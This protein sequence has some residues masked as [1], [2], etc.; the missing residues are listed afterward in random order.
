MGSATLFFRN[1]LIGQDEIDIGF[2]TGRY[3]EGRNRQEM[4]PK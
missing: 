4:E 3:S 1:L 2:D